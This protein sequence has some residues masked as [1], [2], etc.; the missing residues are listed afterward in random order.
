[1][2]Q[3]NF[4]ATIDNGIFKKNIVPDVCLLKGASDMYYRCDENECIL[5]KL[6]RGNKNG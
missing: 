6:L 1:M 5:Q 4:K 3:C 2:I